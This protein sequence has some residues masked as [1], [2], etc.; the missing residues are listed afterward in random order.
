[1]IRAFQTVGLSDVDKVVVKATYQD[2]EAPKLKHVEALIDLSLGDA[3]VAGSLVKRLSSPQFN[4]V[5]KTLVVIHRIALDGDIHFLTHMSRQ[6]SLR[7]KLLHFMDDASLESR[8]L[9]PFTRLYASYLAAK[10]AAFKDLGHSQERL[11]Q[12]ESV[13]WAKNIAPRDLVKSFPVLQFQFG[14]LLDISFRFPDVPSPNITKKAIQLL[15]RDARRLYP[16]LCLFTISVLDH[17]QELQATQLEVMIKC[18]RK[19]QIQNTKFSDWCNWLIGLQLLAQQDSPVSADVLPGNFFSLLEDQYNFRMQQSTQGA[20]QEQLEKEVQLELKKERTAK[21]SAKKGNRKKKRVEGESAQAHST[22]PS[23]TTSRGSMQPQGLDDAF[24]LWEG[25][26][27]A[28]EVSY[29]SGGGHGTPV[30][31]HEKPS[32]NQQVRVQEQDLWDTFRGEGTVSTDLPRSS[33]GTDLPRSSYS[34]PQA[35]AVEPHTS[36]SKKDHFESLLRVKSESGF[37]Q[38]Q[39]DPFNFGAVSPPAYRQPQQIHIQP[40]PTDV[41]SS[42][43]SSQQRSFQGFNPF[44]VLSDSGPVPAFNL[45]RPS[46]ESPRISIPFGSF[47]GAPQQAVSSSKQSLQAKPPPSGLDAFDPFCM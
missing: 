14:T 32:T 13:E 23:A 46:R 40:A 42:L 25:D 47:S 41:F 10:I 18:C 9:S 7:N 27:K 39:N 15:L 34:S 30:G 6:V 44:D 29:G 26:S 35:H 36:A 3:T 31:T 33:F 28:E 8:T 12:R 22:A 2:G 4:V 21:S 16:I 45:P 5:L 24:A 20:M 1:M 37:G 19:H 38:Q 11:E 17:V 43:S